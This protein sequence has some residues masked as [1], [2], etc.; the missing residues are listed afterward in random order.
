MLLIQSTFI[1]PVNAGIQENKDF[2]DPGFHWGDVKATAL[3][4]DGRWSRL[5]HI[6][7]RK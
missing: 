4:L 7:P 5:M 6:T 1:I 3:G 2:L